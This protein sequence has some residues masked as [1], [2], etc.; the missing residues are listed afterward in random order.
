[1]STR[2]QRRSQNRLRSIGGFKDETPRQRYQLE[3]TRANFLLAL[4]RLLGMRSV[5]PDRM[6]LKETHAPRLEVDVDDA[7]DAAT[8][9]VLSGEGKGHG[10][11]PST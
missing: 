10:P 2:S 1:M 8:V 5:R 6:S 4:A 11:C 3:A 7:A 9:R